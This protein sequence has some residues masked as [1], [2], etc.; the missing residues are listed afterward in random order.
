M[1]LLAFA[2]AVTCVSLVGDR[3]TRGVYLGCL[4]L[5]WMFRLASPIRPQGVEVTG[6]G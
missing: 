3:D 6:G 5:W 4:G 2:G 1:R